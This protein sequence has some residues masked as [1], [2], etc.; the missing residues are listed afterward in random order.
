MSIKITASKAA[1]K[2]GHVITFANKINSSI[3][4][5]YTYEVMAFKINL[6]VYNTNFKNTMLEKFK[7]HLLLQ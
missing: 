3:K 4:K 2:K 1:V 6:Q 7:V 5:V